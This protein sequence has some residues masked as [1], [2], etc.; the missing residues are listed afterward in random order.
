[1]LRGRCLCG[2]VSVEV[3]PKEEALHACHCEMCRRWTGAM[4]V[5]VPVAA[6]AFKAEG[7]VRTRATSG[8]AE[9]AWCDECGS[10]LWYRVTAPGPYH[11]AHHVAAGL[12]DDAG[13][14]SSGVRAVYRPRSRRG[15]LL[16][17]HARP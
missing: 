15:M 7:P 14:F 11:N 9:R 3:E 17:A 1:M 10:S 4:L 16:P 5:A 6:D 8:W 13:G 2:A 12:F